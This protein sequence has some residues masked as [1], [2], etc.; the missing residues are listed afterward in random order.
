M[1]KNKCEIIF[2]NLKKDIHEITERF[3][4]TI[5]IIYKKKENDQK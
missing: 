3:I 4:E 1:D 5:L 2:K